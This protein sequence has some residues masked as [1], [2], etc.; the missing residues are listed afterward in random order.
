M[1]LN[2]L[3]GLIMTPKIVA[4]NLICVL[5]FILCGPTVAHIGHNHSHGDEE[6]GVQEFFALLNKSIVEGTADFFI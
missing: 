5:S 1:N 6:E 2:F 4:K 3:N